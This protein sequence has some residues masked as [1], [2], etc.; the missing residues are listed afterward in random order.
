MP[1]RDR[2]RKTAPRGKPKKV[3]LSFTTRMRNRGREF[4]G[5]GSI[6]IN[7]PRQFPRAAL[8]LARRSFR[9][10]WD[11]R[12][13]GMY[14]CG[15]ILTFV[16]L[17]VSMFVSDLLAAG[18]GGFLEDG[19][20]SLIVG[21]FVESFQN[22]LRAFMWPV[23]MMGVLPPWGLAGLIVMFAVFP[24]YLKPPL[25][26]WLFDDEECTTQG[27]GNSPAGEQ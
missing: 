25:E 17:E 7:E 4:V 27:K 15:F 14:A 24:R 6:L 1:A 12:G 19:I 22:S 5:L 23:H 20:F 10:V 11:A 2:K 21:Y 3:K 9:T 18:S 8:G 13:G 16:W 26:Q